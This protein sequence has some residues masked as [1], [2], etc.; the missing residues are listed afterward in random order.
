M[1][2]EE[3]TPPRKRGVAGEGGGQKALD[4]G[5]GWTADSA[6]KCVSPQ[7]ESLQGPPES[8]PAP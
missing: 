8:P 4:S 7:Q 6:G 3:G 1:E 5:G 2:D